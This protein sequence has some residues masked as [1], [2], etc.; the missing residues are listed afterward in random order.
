MVVSHQI[1][2]AEINNLLNNE[3]RSLSDF[4]SMNQTVITHIS[5]ENN[6]EL[7]Q[8]EHAE[9]GKK[10]Y[11]VLNEQQKEIVD[12]V[13]EKAIDI[14][15]LDNNCIYINGPGGFGKTFIYTTIYH[16]LCSKNIKVT[17]MTFTGIAAILLPKG[18]TVHKTFGLPVPMYS[19]SSSSIR[20]QSKEGLLLKETKVFIWDEAPMA[21][22]Y[23][24][25][26][27]NRTLQNI[28]NNNLPFGGKVVVL[29]GDF[30]QLLPIKMN[31]TRTET[32]NLSIKYS[33]S[34]RHFIKYNLTTNMRVL[35]N[36]IDFAKFLLL[37]GDGTLNDQQ[38]NITLPG[39]C[40]LDKNDD[41]VRHVFKKLITEKKFDV[42]S[43]RAILSARNLDVDELNKLVTDLLDITTEHMRTVT[44]VNLMK[45]FCQ[46]I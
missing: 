1:A 7:L 44:T 45:Y 25:E 15:N 9:I 28:M 32:L 37:V 41:I 27:V 13:L 42:I 43:K 11:D 39:H 38:D 40:I 19:D 14:D 46:N 6:D 36:E 10:Q 26:I 5:S 29:G 2:Y 8:T 30:R 18:K 31:G 12:I 22:R 33:E 3:G 24:L 35:P 17:S 23:A 34:W 16:L 21:P 20:A 4:P